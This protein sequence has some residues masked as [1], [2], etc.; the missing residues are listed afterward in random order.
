MASVDIAAIQEFLDLA[1]S[2]GIV[3]ILVFRASAATADTQASVD[4]VVILVILAQVY[5]VIQVTAV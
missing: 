5:L 3:A 4:L 2:V 1:A